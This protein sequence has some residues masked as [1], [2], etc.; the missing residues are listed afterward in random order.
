MVWVNSFF[1]IATLQAHQLKSDVGEQ[2]GD[3][4][5]TPS[6][7]VLHRTRMLAAHYYEQFNSGTRGWGCCCIGKHCLRR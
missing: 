6:E 5:V 2:V 4:L 3:G 1:R 7:V